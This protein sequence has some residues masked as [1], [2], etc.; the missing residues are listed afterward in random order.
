[1]SPS[2]S[3]VILEGI[4]LATEG[5]IRSLQD[6]TSAFPEILKLELILRILLSYLPES[7]EP[8]L[9]T[10]FIRN[11]VSES[12]YDTQNGG[13]QAL[14]TETS[15]EEANHQLR[16]LRLRT[17]HDGFFD[18]D[19]S[20][21]PLSFFLISRA[22]QID[23]ETGNLS[24][25]KELIEPFLDHSR[26]IRI[27]AISTLLPLLRINYERSV[28]HNVS[29]TLEGFEELQGEEAL[30]I[31]LSASDSSNQEPKEAAQL[32]K[33]L[34]SL[35]GPW[36]LGKS[37]RKRRKIGYI[38]DG[39]REELEQPWRTQPVS[40]SGPQLSDW[41]IVN[42]WLHETSMTNLARA[43]QAIE[44]WRGPQD[45]DYGRWATE[46]LEA[47]SSTTLST[48]AYLETVMNIV[49]NSPHTSADCYILLNQILTRLAY[50]TK[51][52]T[53]IPP[54]TPD[55]A[56]TL[57]SVD[58]KFLCKLSPTNLEPQNMRTGSNPLNTPST[59]AIELARALVW[60]GQQ[61]E[62]LGHPLKIGRI[63]QL[64]LFANSEIQHK[65]FQKLVRLLRTH[66]VKND[67]RWTQIRHILLQLRS[68]ITPSVKLR[69]S[70]D[71]P[72]GV[73]SR[74][75]IETF[76]AELLQAFLH[77]GRRSCKVSLVGNNH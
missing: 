29:H 76:E 65:E 4:R 72:I 14:D 11:F 8:S 75:S 16:G 28:S 45:V 53:P 18:F 34:R 44:E 63:A 51:T 31:L 5:D 15:E 24:L 70:K 26:E 58:S 7:V 57:E 23:A 10:D 60:S 66:G 71:T 22:R 59:A 1:M 73:F 48:S 12:L 64:C 46:E 50:L 39:S 19:A 17:L 41:L 27:W 61:L 43:T 20:L 30:S 32:G 47:E 69:H 9:Y 55:C 68:W 42:N 49:Y 62:T 52:D 67:V 74:V 3:H 13:R 21:D 2:P 33:D 56:P 36:I 37:L 25:V 40:P 54:T 6:L 77:N 38:S 35:V